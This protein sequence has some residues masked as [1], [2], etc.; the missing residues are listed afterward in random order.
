[1]TDKQKTLYL[2]T[3]IHKTGTTYIQTV[4]AKNAAMLKQHGLLFPNHGRLADS[5]H[6]NVSYF[7]SAHENLC[8]ENM[9]FSVQNLVDEMQTAPE[10][11]ILISSEEF[12]ICSVD[13]IQVIQSAFHA[14]TVRPIVFLRNPF[15]SIYSIWQEQ[16]KAGQTDLAFQAFIQQDA[17]MN[18]ALHW[19]REVLKKWYQVFGDNMIVAV[20]DNLR[21]ASQN[22]VHYLLNSL[23][24]IDIE[25]Q[26]L[27]NIDQVLNTS[28]SVETAELVRTLRTAQ[29]MNTPL[30]PQWLDNIESN[31]HA[32]L[33]KAKQARYTLKEVFSQQQMIQH[34]SI[35]QD[36]LAQYTHLFTNAYSEACIFHNQ[37]DTPI[38][39]VISEDFYQQYLK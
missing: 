38:F 20:Y 9:P 33:E 12:S 29:Q 22:I 16:M 35:C 34:H 26:K 39:E 10:N 23:L 7:F 32:L 13:E 1:M 19:Q 15:F 2:H 17:I 4:C 5:G 14:F 37:T 28:L 18:I 30:T 25:I 6:H 8:F 24:G 11:K 27:S 31:N 36:M 3:G 21:N